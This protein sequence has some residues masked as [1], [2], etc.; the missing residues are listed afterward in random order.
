VDE[1]LIITSKIISDKKRT[2]QAVAKIFGPEGDLLAEAEGLM[3]AVPQSDLE[4][5]DLEELGW[6]VYSDEEL[7]K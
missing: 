6:R 7:L 4:T 1:K 5:M 3:V 2:G